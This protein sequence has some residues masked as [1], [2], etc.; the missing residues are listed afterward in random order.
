MFTFIAYFIGA[1]IIILIL[2]F[3]LNLFF[4]R[5]TVREKLTVLQSYEQY[6]KDFIQEYEKELP[7]QSTPD[8]LQDFLEYAENILLERSS[9]PSFFSSIPWT[10]KYTSFQNLL[11]AAELYLKD[12]TKE[13]YQCEARL[14]FAWLILESEKK[15]T[16][17]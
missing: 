6:Q 16:D 8:F 7:S 14:L 5:R 3:I 15:K 2:I 4:F 17:E 1:V 10:Q 13:Q 11:L 9:N 12:D